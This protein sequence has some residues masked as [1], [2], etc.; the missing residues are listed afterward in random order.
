M[1]MK[2]PDD[3]HPRPIRDLLRRL[4]KA[5]AAL[6][7]IWPALLVVGGYFAWHQWGADHVAERFYGVDATLIRINPARPDHDVVVV[8]VASGEVAFSTNVLPV[9]GAGSIP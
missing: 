4:I 8:D 9:S 6:S 7:V 1:A 5:P 3:D 2:S